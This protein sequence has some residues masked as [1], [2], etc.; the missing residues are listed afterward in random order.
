MLA[1]SYEE[2]GPFIIVIINSLHCCH[3]EYIIQNIQIK[4]KIQITNMFLYH[5]YKEKGN[6]HFQKK[7]LG[8]VV[9]VLGFWFTVMYIIVSV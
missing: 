1:L 9:T 5:K 4:K 2:L 3:S 6:F 8:L 7:S